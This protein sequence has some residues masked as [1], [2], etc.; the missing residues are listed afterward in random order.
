MRGHPKFKHEEKVKF[1]FGDEIKEGT[2]CII[3]EYGTFSDPSDVSYDIM[4]TMDDGRKCL[5]K[6]V[7][8][9]FVSK[10]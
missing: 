7:T 8:E 3:D 4:S 1:Q 2:I 9:K 6:H 5:Y 10:L